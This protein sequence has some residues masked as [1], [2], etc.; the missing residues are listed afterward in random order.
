MAQEP[1]ETGGAERQN[2]PQDSATPG[3]VLLNYCPDPERKLEISIPHKHIDQTLEVQDGIVS[4]LIEQRER[5][6]GDENCPKCGYYNLELK[7]L[8]DEI[9]K[10]TKLQNALSKKGI[11]SMR[12]SDEA[13]S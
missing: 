5:L 2:E 11:Q 8:L 7:V 3:A 1:E 12:E 4:R 9:D 6:K 10:L 13:R